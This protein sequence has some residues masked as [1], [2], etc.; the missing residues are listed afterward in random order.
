VASGA[1]QTAQA[2]VGLSEMASNLKKSI[3]QFKLA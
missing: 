2:C 3:G 1:D